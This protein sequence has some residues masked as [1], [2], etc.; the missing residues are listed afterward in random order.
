MALWRNAMKYGFV[1]KRF[2]G[3]PLASFASASNWT[4]LFRLTVLP[5]ST[6]V[7]T[8]T[9]ETS[10]CTLT[11]NFTGPFGEEPVDGT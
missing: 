10:A 7:G 2:S 1:R 9:T 5:A 11:L 3:R 6:S 4:P 8:S